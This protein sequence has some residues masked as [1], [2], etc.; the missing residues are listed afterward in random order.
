MAIRFSA[1]LDS[2]NFETKLRIFSSGLGGIFKELMKSVGEEMTTEAKARAPSR[3]GKLRN[4]INFIVNNDT[5]FVFTTRKSLKKS[6][7]WYSR[8]VEKD[9]HIKPKKG[10]YLIFKINGE[11]KKVDSVNVKGQPYMTPVFNSYFE[12]DN[13]KGYRALQD[14]LKKKMAEYLGE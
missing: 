4:N 2:K 8:I 10:K 13:G 11:W 5:E 14:A 3:T 7:V 12:S 1:D 9:R 6:N